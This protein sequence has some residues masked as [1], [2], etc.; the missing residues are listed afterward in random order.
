MG[1][2]GVGDGN[3]A[4]SF[5]E[6]CRIRVLGTQAHA[7]KAGPRLIHQRRYQRSP[8]ALISPRLPDVDAP[9]TAHVRTSG[10]GVYVKS[11]HGYQQA[12]IQ[13]TAE[14]LSGSVEAVLTQVAQRLDGTEIR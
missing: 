7:A 12:L 8:N 3:E 4:D 6:P 13:M 11:A 5:V 10:K 2:V 9:Y 14:R 1:S